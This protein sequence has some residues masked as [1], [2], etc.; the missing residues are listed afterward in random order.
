MHRST[1]KIIIEVGN[2]AES[3][4]GTPLYLSDKL[5]A[6]GVESMVKAASTFVAAD[7]D[8]TR[9]IAALWIIEAHL[10]FISRLPESTPSLYP[11]FWE[12][13]EYVSMLLG[14]RTSWEE[15]CNREFGGLGLPEIAA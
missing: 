8:P 5:A 12:C 10:F 1:S 15:R 2:I 6:E 13:I 7:S 4:K 9:L 14:D 3:L 11:R